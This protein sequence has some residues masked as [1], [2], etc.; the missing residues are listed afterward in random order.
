MLW[1]SLKL[2]DLSGG[3]INVGEKSASRFAVEADG[4]YELIMLFDATRP[5]HRIVL[6]PIV[7]LF[8]GRVRLEMA[9]LALEITHR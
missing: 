1:I 5:S 2:R 8:D 7:P 4:W 3:F 9:A 6:N